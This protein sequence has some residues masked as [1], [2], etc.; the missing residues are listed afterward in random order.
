MLSAHMLNM[1]IIR[2]G[3]NGF[4]KRI[5]VTYYIILRY[6]EVQLKSYTIF[7]ITVIVI[8]IILTI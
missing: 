4:S 2:Q 1:S 8:L 7:G 5:F 6:D 3:L